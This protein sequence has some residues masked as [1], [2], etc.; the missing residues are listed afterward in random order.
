VLASDYYYPAPLLAAFRLAADG[1]LPLAK[2]WDLISAAPARAAG[3]E[4]RGVI[5]QGRRADIILVDD[6][7]AL[8]PR[9]VAVIAAGQLVHLAD[10]N[11]LVHSTLASRKAV[12][13]A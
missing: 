7:V 3:L 8:R 4:D 9:V 5:A 11:R 13:A 12:A 2:A 1:I 6:R 10:A